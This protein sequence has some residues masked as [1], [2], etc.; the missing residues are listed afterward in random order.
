M[1]CSGGR[2]ER[3]SSIRKD[4]DP[5]GT[6]MAMAFCPRCRRDMGQTDTVCPHCG[7]DFP[8]LP[9]GSRQ[10]PGLAY[11]GL[12]TLSLIVGQTIAGL[13]CLSAVVGCVVALFQGN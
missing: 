3:S 7:Y 8:D 13:G 4:P 5:G 10:R 11:S 2:R 9:A 6:A 12:A 1:S